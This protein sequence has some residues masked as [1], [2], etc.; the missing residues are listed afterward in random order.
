M[1]KKLEY[2]IDALKSLPG[3]GIRQAKTIANFLIHKDELYVSEFI[4][5]IVEAKRN[6]HFCKQCNNLLE[7][8]NAICDICS[9]FTRENNELC[10]VSSTEDLDK[11]EETKHFKGLYFVLNEEVKMKSGKTISE[12]NLKK[13]FD[14]INKYQFKEIII[15][16]NWTNDGEATASLLKRKINDTYPNIALFRLAVGMPINSEIDYADKTTLKHALSNKF[17]Y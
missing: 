17:K 2:L 15:A 16:T 12:A 6:I 8:E 14:M 4:N 1:D 10:I 11:I 5:R 3:V 9:D 7:G 13:L